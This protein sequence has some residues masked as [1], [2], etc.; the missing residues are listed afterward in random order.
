MYA[1]PDY[2]PRTIEYGLGV[3]EFLKRYYPAEC[4]SAFFPLAA[5]C[6]DTEAEKR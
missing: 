6:C 2:L 5:L 4:P 1:D 3:K